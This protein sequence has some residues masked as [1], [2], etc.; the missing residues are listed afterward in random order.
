MTTFELVKAR[1]RLKIKYNKLKQ[2]S[3]QIRAENS[4]LV[5]ANLDL[6]SKLEW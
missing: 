2:V 3:K 5:R 1:D 4:Q 6:K